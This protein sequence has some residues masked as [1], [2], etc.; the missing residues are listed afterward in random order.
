[1]RAAVACV[2][3]PP[4]IKSVTHACSCPSIARQVL[5]GLDFLHSKCSII[6]TDLKPENVLIC[7]L[8]NEYQ[9]DLEE[10][11]AALAAQV[12]MYQKFPISSIKHRFVTP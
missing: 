6:H 11:A 4:F 10:E 7:P 9:D 3:V 5:E 8:V 12:C 2:C 1:M